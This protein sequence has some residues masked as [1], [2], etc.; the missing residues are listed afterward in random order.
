MICEIV[1][2]VD[3][4]CVNKG[5][6]EKRNDEIIKKM[7]HRFLVVCFSLNKITMRK[8]EIRILHYKIWT[9]RLEFE[10]RARFVSTHLKMKCLS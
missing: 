2:E 1:V 8:I 7:F 4:S 9:M 3:C 6:K 10:V 5:K